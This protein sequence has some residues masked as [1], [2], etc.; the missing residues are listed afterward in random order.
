M[1]LGLFSLFNKCKSNYGSNYLRRLF[2]QPLN[3][4]GKLNRRLDDIES[5]MNFGKDIL[6]FYYACLK[7]IKSLNTIVEKMKIMTLNLKQ[8]SV[9]AQTVEN[10]IAINQYVLQQ[11]SELNVYN[12]LKENYP[13]ELEFIVNDIKTVINLDKSVED[14]K[15]EINANVNEEFDKMKKEF[16]NIEQI[17]LEAYE[18]EKSSKLTDL[19]PNFQIIFS[20]V[21]GFVIQAHRE[22][23]AD[24]KRFQ[25]SLKNITY[26]TNSDKFKY[27]K[28]K[29]LA[30]YDECY[31]TLL[32]EISSK[33]NAI[34]LDLQNGILNRLPKIFQFIEV[35]G[36]L[37]W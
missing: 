14:K 27:F 7:K 16:E 19:I 6:Y 23:V 18:H 25:L 29:N 11:P 35:I 24:D 36:E 3:D 33:Q 26:I 15:I 9:L 20:P 4:Y 30:Q 28:T 8:F 22:H 31:L 12:K 21:Y 37:D 34:L 10:L 1:I 32:N 5:I 2:F 17:I 13:I